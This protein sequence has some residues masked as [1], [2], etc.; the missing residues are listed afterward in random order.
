MLSL[1]HRRLVCYCRL[2]EVPDP[3]KPQKLGLHQREI[4][5]FND[6]LVVCGPAGAGLG[7]QTPAS[8]R[9]ERSASAAPGPAPQP[10]GSFFLTPQ[11][12]PHGSP[13]RGSASLSPRTGGLDVAERGSPR[14]R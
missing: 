8:S 9:M 13:S 2:F 5:L 7:A 10:P 1:P 11:Q 14:G 4:F 3:N 6:L 12:R